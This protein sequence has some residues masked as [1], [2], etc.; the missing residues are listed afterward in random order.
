MQAVKLAKQ[1]SVSVGDVV[2][3]ETD[4]ITRKAIEV[5]DVI[6]VAEGVDG[7]IVE[8]P[9]RDAFDTNKAKRIALEIA[10]RQRLED[11]VVDH[12]TQ[13]RIP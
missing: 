9:R 11:A 12:Q 10:W 3:I 4:P 1:E 6:V 5:N 2:A 8:W 13:M 7:S